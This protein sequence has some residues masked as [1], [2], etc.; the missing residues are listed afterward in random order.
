MSEERGG[1]MEAWCYGLGHR[2]VGGSTMALKSVGPQASPCSPKAAMLWWDPTKCLSCLPFF[3]RQRTPLFQKCH[4]RPI[5]PIPPESLV[6]SVTCKQKSLEELWENLRK[7][8]IPL[9]YA[10]ALHPSLFSSA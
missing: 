8:Q 6:Y 5:T 4:Y 3:I 10:S 2:M 1:K 7:G 9:A